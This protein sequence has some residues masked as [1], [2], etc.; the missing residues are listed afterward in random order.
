MTMHLKRNGA[1][2]YV[3]D[4][5]DSRYGPVACSCEH[6]NETAGSIKGCEFLSQLSNYDF[7]MDYASLSYV[8]VGE[9]FYIDVR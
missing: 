1:R 3:L 9:I 7:V 2:K 4:L 6:G 8:F 5:I